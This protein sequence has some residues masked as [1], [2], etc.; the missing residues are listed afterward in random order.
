MRPHIASAALFAAFLFPSSAQAQD[1]TPGVSAQDID[2]VRYLKARATDTARRDALKKGLG[3]KLSGP[4][5][6][7]RVTFEFEADDA[8]DTTFKVKGILTQF[9]NVLV[10]RYRVASLKEAVL[11]TDHDREHDD[12]TRVIEARGRDVLVISGKAAKDEKTV[13][14]IR[15]LAW[16]K[17]TQKRVDVLGTQSSSDDL[18]FRF[19]KQAAAA[20]PAVLAKVKHYGQQLE[21]L[22]SMIPG[23]KLTK[24]GD[25]SRLD[26]DGEIMTFEGNAK[27]TTIGMFSSAANEQR[28]TSLFA[29]ALGA[30]PANNG[31]GLVGGLGGATPKTTRTVGKSDDGKTIGVVVGQAIRVEL[32][33]NPTTGYRWTRKGNLPSGVT[34]VKEDFSGAGANGP[35]GSGG[36]FSFELMATKKGTRTLRFQY[37]RSWESS[38]IETFTIKLRVK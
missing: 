35:V 9:K 21:Q 10:A 4:G 27:H 12:E 17:S 22:A 26:M 14:A 15:E 25:R 7:G 11:F 33:G 20:N 23:A 28:M 30:R 6:V 37:K 13:L 2:Q 5:K 29:A 34:L 1:V 18:L 24:D 31:G 19:S 32:A 3:S 8:D 38:A 36:T 16:P